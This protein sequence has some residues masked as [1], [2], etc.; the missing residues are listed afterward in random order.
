MSKPYP[1]PAKQGISNWIQRTIFNLMYEINY[2]MLF[3]WIQFIA[4]L[5]EYI[6]A[7]WTIL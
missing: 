4:L 1:K 5:Y 2:P 6:P 3:E 7:V